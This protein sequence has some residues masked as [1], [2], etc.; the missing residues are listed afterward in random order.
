MYCATHEYVLRINFPS[1]MELRIT[2]PIKN[3][4]C[5]S[6]MSFA[7]TCKSAQNIKGSDFVPGAV[8]AVAQVPKRVPICCANLCM[9]RIYLMY[10]RYSIHI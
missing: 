1:K 2:D 10:K 9:L 8:E 3:G 7:L 4:I 5:A 6:E